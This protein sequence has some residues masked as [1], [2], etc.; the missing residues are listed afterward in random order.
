MPGD[1]NRSIMPAWVPGFLARFVN[2]IQRRWAPYV[3]PY[4]VIV[5]TGR[6]SG[7]AH[8]SPVIAY[9]RGDTVVVP[10]PYGASAQWVKNVCAADGATILRRGRQAT[11]TNP[12]VIAG[13]PDP[14][15]SRTAT[16][17]AHCVP[18]LACDVDDGRPPRR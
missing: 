7:R 6:R 18:L 3:P 17:L 14:A 9:R 15:L 5:H 11:L 8:R 1:P 2:P 4:P 10:L 12:R 13:E 16:L